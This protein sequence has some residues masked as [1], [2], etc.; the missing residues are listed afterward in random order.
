MA[1]YSD[2]KSGPVAV[3]D[4][5]SG[6]TSAHVDA[7][8]ACVV[9]PWFGGRLERDAMSV[10]MCQ[11]TKPKRYKPYSSEFKREALLRASEEGM[12]G[13][14]VC[15][16][17]RIRRTVSS[18]YQA[19]RCHTPQSCSGRMTPNAVRLVHQVSSACPS[20]RCSLANENAG[21]LPTQAL[22]KTSHESSRQRPG[23]RNS[24]NGAPLFRRETVESA[25]ATGT[26]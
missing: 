13:Q 25:C 18:P 12:T 1:G 17:L 19:Q 4:S 7:M 11:L 26:H 24:S 15:D 3:S 23:T 9:L 16:E 20:R 21:W 14:A 8:P 2:R 6:R 10:S 5:V 22:S